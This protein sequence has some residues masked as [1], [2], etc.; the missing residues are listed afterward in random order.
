[1]AAALLGDVPFRRRTR[2]D[3]GAVESNAVRHAYVLHVYH[4][5]TVARAVSYDD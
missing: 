5:S 3:M 1:L 4:A 2:D